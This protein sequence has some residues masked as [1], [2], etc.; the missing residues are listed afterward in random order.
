MQVESS[1]SDHFVTAHYHR[2]QGQQRGLVQR[3]LKP[4]NCHGLFQHETEIHCQ[5][6]V[7]SKLIFLDVATG[8]P[9]SIHHARMLQ[10]T[11]L[12]K[13]VKANMILSKPSNVIENKEVPLLLI[14]NGAH[15]ATSCQLKPYPFTIRLNNTEKK[16]NKKLSSAQV[17]VEGAIALLKGRW[18]CLLK[19]LNNRLNNVSFIIIASCV[20]HNI[21]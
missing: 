9:G 20:L 17:T 14:S 8:F 13:D 19:R 12:Y 4:D 6:V 11:K 10:A 1:Y 3:Y 2:F 21:C 15:Q 18:R 7:G 5:A 16:I